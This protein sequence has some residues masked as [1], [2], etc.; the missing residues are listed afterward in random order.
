MRHGHCRIFSHSLSVGA[1]CLDVLTWTN[2]YK[3]TVALRNLVYALSAQPDKA[4]AWHREC[5]FLLTFAGVVFRAEI[6]VLVFS[7]SAFL[8]INKPS[9]IK[10]VIIP[11]GM[12]GAV[13]GLVSTVIVDSYFWQRF[14]SWPEFEGFYYN[15][16]LGKSSEWGVSPPQ[17]YFTNALPKLMLNPLTYMQ[18]IPLAIGQPA[19]RL[20]S[21]ALLLPSLTFI[22]VYSFLPHKE[23]RFIIYVLPALTA[24]ASIGASWIWTR[25][26]K[27]FPYRILAAMLLLSTLASYAASAGLLAISR[28]NYPG[29]EAVLRLQRLTADSASTVRVHADNLACQT[30]LTRFLEDRSN[31]TASGTPRWTFDKTDEPSKLLDPLFWAEFDYVIAEQPERTIG[32]FEVVDVV[33][34]YAGIAIK[35]PG[36]MLD[37]RG[38][39]ERFVNGKM[40]E[41][42][43]WEAKWV[44]LGQWAREFTGGWWPVVRM[45]PKLRILRKQKSPVNTVVEEV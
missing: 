34:G 6:A 24:V 28:L 41:L 33:R 21:L 20:R 4:S 17:Y 10:S 11:A 3:A 15:T 23:W 16:V 26:S 32:K 7:V 22:F 12:T 31:T 25:R 36:Q 42:E 27:G 44:E 30:G 1:V 9:S 29:G 13:A 8:A 38:F 37:D 19:T 40:V 14:P 5:L 45:E 35:K 18:L 43:P 2:S 39:G